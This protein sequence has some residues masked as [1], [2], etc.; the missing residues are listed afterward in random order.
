MKPLRSYRREVENEEIMGGKIK[1][2][3][4]KGLVQ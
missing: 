4:K 3:D 1:S 2:V